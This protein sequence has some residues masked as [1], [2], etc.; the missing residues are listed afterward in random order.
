MLC[1]AFQQP[2][3]TFCTP[4]PR[5]SHRVA[6]VTLNSINIMFIAVTALEQMYNF[7]LVAL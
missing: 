7:L 1:K 2:E 5:D 3:L 6:L 4:L